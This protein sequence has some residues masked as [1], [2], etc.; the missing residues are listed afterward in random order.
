[1]SLPYRVKVG[2]GVVS[3]LL[4]IFIGLFFLF[5]DIQ[6]MSGILGL[7]TLIILMMVGF[8]AYGMIY[9]EDTEDTKAIQLTSCPDYQTMSMENPKVT[10]KDGTMVRH[11]D[12]RKFKV[13]KPEIRGGEKDLYVTGKYAQAP[14]KYVS[15]ALETEQKFDNIYQNRTTVLKYKADGTIVEDNDLKDK[16]DYKELNDKTNIISLDHLNKASE[17]AVSKSDF[18][19]ALCECGLNFGWSELSYEC[20]LP[21]REYARSDDQDKACD[22]LKTQITNAIGNYPEMLS[23]NVGQYKDKD[24]DKILNQAL[25]ND[26]TTVETVDGEKKVSKFDV[27]MLQGLNI[28]T[29]NDNNKFHFIHNNMNVEPDLTK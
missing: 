3:V 1:M 15:T 5:P 16:V 13:C 26:V 4:V 2:L 29:S 11:K 17:L 23:K 27:K 7:F 20:G 24:T 28:G 18:N 9:Q 10:N 22:D 14:G 19:K 25:Y 21:L 8:S 12:D 6:M